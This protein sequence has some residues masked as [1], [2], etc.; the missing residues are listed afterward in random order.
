MKNFILIKIEHCE[1]CPSHDHNGMFQH[2]PYWICH[3]AKKKICPIYKELRKE[4]IPDWCPSLESTKKVIEE[5]RG[6]K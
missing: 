5:I 3:S 6:Q 4:K 1:Q 2:D